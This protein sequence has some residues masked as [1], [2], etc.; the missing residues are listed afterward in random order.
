MLNL[1]DT[2]ETGKAFIKKLYNDPFPDTM[3]K[4]VINCERNETGGRMHLSKIRNRKLR[5]SRHAKDLWYKIESLNE[6][7]YRVENTT[8]G[9]R[10]PFAKFKRHT[11]LKNEA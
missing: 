5:A 2:I 10:S 7:K 1:E 8:F 11:I 4:T 3:E 9:W 6:S